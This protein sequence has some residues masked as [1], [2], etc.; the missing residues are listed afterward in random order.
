MVFN[1]R[2]NIATHITPGEAYELKELFF[3]KILEKGG[4]ACH[5]RDCMGGTTNIFGVGVWVRVACT[6]KMHEGISLV[7]L[8]G[9]SLLS[10]GTF[11]RGQTYHT[12]APGHQ[13][14][15]LRA[16]LW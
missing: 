9:T 10:G 13:G 5:T 2:S 6:S 11:G 1:D 4:I 3:L 15:V 12:V 8:N 14:G 7:C 16:C